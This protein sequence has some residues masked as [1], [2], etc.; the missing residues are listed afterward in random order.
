M[1]KISIHA[2]KEGGK[3]KKVGKYEEF[4]DEEMLP[5]DSQ[6]SQVISQ[7]GLFD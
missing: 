5:Q 1:G 3:K 2:G 6:H 4:V 7:V